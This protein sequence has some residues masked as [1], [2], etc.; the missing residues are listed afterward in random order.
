MSLSLDIQTT[1]RILKSN[2]TTYVEVSC[3]QTVCLRTNITST[4]T[5]ELFGVLNILKTF[6]RIY[7][8]I[9]YDSV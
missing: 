1:R 8:P 3:E 6:D 5:L 2:N 4:L 7:N 9:A